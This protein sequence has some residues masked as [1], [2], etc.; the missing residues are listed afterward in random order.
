M[1]DAGP[2]LLNVWR[3]GMKKDGGEPSLVR[4]W[5]VEPQSMEPESIILSIEL[6]AHMNAICDLRSGCS[7]RR[8]R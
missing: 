1:E 4:Q 2:A 8:Y 6:R 7:C 3:A 5:G